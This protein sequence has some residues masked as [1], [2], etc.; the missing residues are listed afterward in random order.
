MGVM[1]EELTQT[2]GLAERWVRTIQTWPKVVVGLLAAVTMVA[3][4]FAAQVGVDNAVDVWFVDND[5]SLIR[6][7]DFQSTFGNDEVVVVGVSAGED[8]ISSVEGLKRL[9]AVDQDVGRVAGI[10]E[11]RSAA[12]VSAIRGDVMGLEI[13]PVVPENGDITTEEAEGFAQAI[14]VDPGLANLVSVDGSMGLVLAEMETMDD[15]DAERDGILANLYEAVGAPDLS[16]AGIGVIYAAL[17]QAS[18]VGAAV[19]I[20]ASY[21]LI[22][23]LLWRLLGRIGPV[24]LTLGVVGLGATWLMGIYGGSGRDINMVTMVM[25]TLVLVIGVSDC[26]HM[27]SHAAE[28]NPELPVRERIR[29]GVSFVFWPCLFNTLTTGMGFLALST[30]AMPVIRDLGIFSAAGL[31]AAFVLAVVGCSSMVT[32]ASMIPKTTSSGRIQQWV[33]M[34][35]R[36]AVE[37]HRAV[38]VVGGFV[39][40]IGA[41]GVT[42]IVVDTYSIDFLYPSHPIRQDSDVI[43]SQFGPTTPLE[44]VVRSDDGVDNLA[45][46]TAIA[47][48]QTKLKDTLGC[49]SDWVPGDDGCVGWSRSVADPVWRLNQVMT[50]RA[51]EGLP[52]PSSE[53]AFEQLLFLVESDSDGDLDRFFDPDRLATRVTVGIPMTSA[54]GFADMMQRTSALAQ[55]PDGVTLEPNGYLP[56][57][58]R[59]MD[60]IVQSQLSSFGLAFVVIFCLIGVLFR[61]VRMAALAIPANLLPVLMTLGLM[62]IL[63][64]RLDVATV[65]IAAIVLG[66]VVDDTVQFLYRY[67]HELRRAEGDVVSAVGKTVRGVGR[68]MAITT[69]VLGLG[70]SVLG[71]AGVKSVAFFGLLLAFALTSAL[72]AD[73]LVIPALLVALAQRS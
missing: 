48:W 59:M 49:A 21:L 18:T 36:L 38:L 53:A 11:V 23:I 17:N 32:R 72:F 20:S 61:S 67:R 44:F 9:R 35:A 66:L 4:F 57:Y 6:Y 27:L 13:G 25:P 54:R 43:E 65:T 73:L 58:V 64:I 28:Q 16:F 69:V 22:T 7:R 5:P 2:D 62:G 12:S 29:R 42:R 63:G 8:G 40:L 30:A 68:P 19:V 33:E 26:V 55:F 52:P 39:G 50:D 41:L 60:Y 56:L 1:A 14:Q 24:L 37:R 15:I 70:F 3:G 46:M 71:L 34:A 31:L 47:D 45:V 10:A 51:S